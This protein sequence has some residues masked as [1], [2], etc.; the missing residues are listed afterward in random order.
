MRKKA[1]IFLSAPFFLFFSFWIKSIEF[2][3]NCTDCNLILAER[4]AGN[5]AID[6][7][8][9]SGLRGSREKKGARRRG[10]LCYGELFSVFVLCMCPALPSH[11]PACVW[12]SI[13]LPVQPWQPLPWRQ[14]GDEPRERLQVTEKETEGET[15]LKQRGGSHWR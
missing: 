14:S 5:E 9:G 3:L 12:T 8:E 1:D 4:P 7:T 2:L 11:V 6:H 10:Y 15:D 13:K